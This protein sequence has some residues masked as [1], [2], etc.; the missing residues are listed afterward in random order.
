MPPFK[1]FFHTLHPVITGF[2]EMIIAAFEMQ[3]RL[4]ILR[5]KTGAVCLDVFV[6]VSLRHTMPAPTLFL[7]LSSLSVLPQVMRET[8]T[9]VK[10]P[11]KLKIG[12]KSKKGE[13]FLIVQSHHISALCFVSFLSHVFLCSHKLIY[14]CPFTMTHS[15]V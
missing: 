11:S 10:W 5:S 12:A 4:C 6:C 15:N 8:D 13:K 14:H 9:Q 7:T 1:H 2:M 3:T